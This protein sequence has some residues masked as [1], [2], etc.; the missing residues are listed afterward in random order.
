VAIWSVSILL[1]PR[2]IL[3]LLSATTVNVLPTHSSPFTRIYGCMPM[4][5]F[6]LV[7]GTAPGYAYTSQRT[8]LASLCTVVAPPPWLRVRSLSIKSKPSVVGFYLSHIHQT[9]PRPSRC[10]AYLSRQPMIAFFLYHHVQIPPFF[11]LPFS[12]FYHPFTSFS[13]PPFPPFSSL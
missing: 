7:L 12:F 8:S 6:Q 4:A 5:P 2:M 10:T 11:F 3:H 13:L 1:G 9:T